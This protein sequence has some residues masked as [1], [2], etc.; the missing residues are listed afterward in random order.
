MNI[1]GVVPA[2]GNSKSI[3]QKNL[4]NLAGKPLLAYTAECALE[5]KLLSRIIL[6]TDDPT[7]AEVGQDLGL[8]VPFLRPSDLAQDE[9]TILPVLQNLLAWFEKHEGYRADAIVLLQPTSPFRQSHHIDQA[10]EIFVEKNADTVVSVVRVPHQ[11]EPNSLMQ[12]RDGELQAWLPDPIILRRQ[13]KATL[14]ARNGP[15]V[16]VMRPEIIQSG[17]LY[18]GHTFHLEMDL[19]SS[20]DIDEPVDLLFAEHLYPL[21]VSELDLHNG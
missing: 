1:L 15:A 18:G 13:E 16:L 8:E 17:D 7:I 10:I 19:I 9:T 14:F 6:S 12:L 4:A 11:F 3:P 21:W 20:I 2:R 5:S